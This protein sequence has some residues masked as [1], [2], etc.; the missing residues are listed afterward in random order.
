MSIKKGERPQDIISNEVPKN[1][2]VTSFTAIPNVATLQLIRAQQRKEQRKNIKLNFT[3]TM[4]DAFNDLCQDLQKDY[5]IIEPNSFLKS[6]DPLQ[7]LSIC[8]EEIA[9]L[10]NKGY[11]ISVHM[12][13]KIRLGLYA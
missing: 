3:N 8:S 11:H 1:P 2:I 12:G 10:K 7:I 4:R 6:F 9:E 5:I 13:T